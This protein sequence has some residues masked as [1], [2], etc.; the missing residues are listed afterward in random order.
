VKS[1]R[2]S[3]FLLFALLLFAIPVSAHA[4]V[5]VSVGFAPPA[6]PVYEQ[7]I[8]PA[9]NLMWT[10]GYWGYGLG[11]YFWVPGAWEPA[12]YVGA[13]W[14]PGYWG[15]SGGA[16]VFNE[17]YWGPHVGFYGGVN[18]GFGYGGIGFVGGMWNGGVFSYNTAVMR[19]TPR[20]STTPTSTKPS[21]T[22]TPWRT[23]DVSRITA[24]KGASTGD[25]LPRKW[26]LRTIGT[27]RRLA[28]SGS[29]LPRRGPT[30]LRMPRP[31]A[32]TR[33]T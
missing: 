6:L 9:P 5:F 18:Y 14:T 29:A 15:W 3:R 12:P 10:P 27:R 4:G 16:F 32:A 26:L 8:C 31:T 17:G 11:G 33:P 25:P 22:R 28:N 1:L 19:V 30:R 2:F 23:A 7:P 21:F 24:E 13:L 20:S